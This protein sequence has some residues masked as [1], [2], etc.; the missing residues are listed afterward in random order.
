MYFF[1]VQQLT[2][3]GADMVY[4]LFMGDYFLNTKGFSIGQTGLLVSLPLWG[5]AIGGVLGG[6]CNDWLIRITGSRRWSRSTVGFR[7]QVSGLHIDV[8]GDLPR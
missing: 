8:R 3:A 6:F 2:S 1:V 4:S 5:G 7:R